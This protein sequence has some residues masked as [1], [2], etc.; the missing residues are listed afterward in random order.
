MYYTY[1]PSSI[2]Y[3][4]ELGLAAPGAAPPLRLGRPPGL[5]LLEAHVGN[6]RFSSSRSNDSFSINRSNSS[7]SIHRSNGSFS[8]NRS[9]D[10]FSINSSNSSF[11]INSSNSSFSINSSNNSY[12]INS[13]NTSYSINSSIIWGFDRLAGL[14]RGP[15]SIYMFVAC[16]YNMYNIYIIRVY[17]YIYIYIYI[18]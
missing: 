7:F 13:S 16:I 9:N 17:I 8:I 14:V 11:S 12:S 18:I 2:L 15:S 5:P 4:E 1:P 6:S 10:S 3:I